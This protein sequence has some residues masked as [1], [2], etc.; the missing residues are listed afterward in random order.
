MI[1]LAVI[2]EVLKLGSGI[3]HAHSRVLCFTKSTTV[4]PKMG[5]LVG[6]DKLHGRQ[7]PWERE[8]EGPAAI[9]EAVRS[10]LLVVHSCSPSPVNGRSCGRAS[11][12]G[13]R[14]VTQ[15]H[16]MHTTVKRARLYVEE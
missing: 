2:Q 5:F 8:A 1:F 9:L 16:D 11:K 13:C 4:A 10:R 6:S 12:A 14:D 15:H 7:K 3:S